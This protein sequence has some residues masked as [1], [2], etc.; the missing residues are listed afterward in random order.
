MQ[1][2]IWWATLGQEICQVRWNTSALQDP[3][4][5]SSAKKGEPPARAPGFFVATGPTGDPSCNSRGPG[6]C[7][8]VKF[9]VPPLP[10]WT[11]TRP[12][13]YLITYLR[14]HECVGVYFILCVTLQ[15][16][17]YSVL[18]ALEA[19]MFFSTGPHPNLFF[20]FSFYGRTCSMWKSPG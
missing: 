7:L 18:Q 5:Q 8:V 6:V 11:V 15:Y 2:G 1:K 4:C 16:N 13:C 9:N 10:G 12:A 20:S 3:T 19:P 17:H 14:Q